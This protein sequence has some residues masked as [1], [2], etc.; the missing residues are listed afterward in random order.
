MIRNFIKKLWTT[1]GQWIN[2]VLFTDTGEN[3]ALLWVRNNITRKS[4]LICLLIAE[5]IFWLPNIVTAILAITVSKWFWTIFT[6][7]I[8]FWSGPF[9]PAVPLQLA[10]ALVIETVY[11]KI[12][13]R[14]QNKSSG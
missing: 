8:V 14:K 5:V 7:I 13:R 1:I 9:T 11:R 12:H 3:R 4:Y 6:A 2:R 10:L